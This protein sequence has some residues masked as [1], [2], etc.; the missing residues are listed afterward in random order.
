MSEHSDSRRYDAWTRR[1]AERGTAE[2][3]P[4]AT[5][6]VLRDRDDDLEVLM[7]RKN[8]RIAFGGM[9][10]FPGGRIDDAD[11]VLDE[12]GRPD[13]LATAA[14]EEV[15]VRSKRSKRLR[16]LMRK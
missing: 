13:E 1:H 16:I 8:S 6:L 12:D 4:A 2:L 7:L 10:V 15:F 14:A 11:E 9:W 3:I 5:V